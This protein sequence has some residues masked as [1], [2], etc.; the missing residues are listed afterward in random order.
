MK[1]NLS[2]KLVFFIFL[3][4]FIS[5]SQAPTVGLV[6]AGGGISEGYTLFSPEQNNEVYLIDNCGE[7]INS[8][9]FSENPGLT[10]YLLENGTLL[11]AGTDSLEIRSWDNTLIWSYELTS[12]NENQHH[13]I[14]PLP[15]GNIFVISTDKYS[16]SEMVALGR[17]PSITNNN[18]R[19]EKIIEIEPVGMNQANVVWEWK[20]IDHLIQ[21]AD[22]TKPNY[23]VI[24]DHPELLDI[25]YDNGHTGDWVHLN[26]IDY[27][28]QLDQIIISARHLGEIYIIDH[29]TTALEAAVHAGGVSNRGGDF[30]WRWGNNSVYQQG[31]INDQLLFEQ[32][33]A[34]WV[35][36][37]YPNE[38]KIS[39]FNNG[40]DGTNSFS[41]IHLIEPEI[42]GNSYGMASNQFL[43]MTYDWSWNGTL[44]GV[45]LFANKKCG[46]Q[47]LQNGNF[48][49]TQTQLGQAYEINSLGELVWS[50]KNPHGT[51]VYSQNDI[52]PNEANTIFRA[53]KYTPDF[54][55]FSG[56]TL[57]ASGPIENFNDLSEACTIDLGV[58]NDYQSI[59]Y[60]EN[61][62]S[63]GLIKFNNEV[64]DLSL[65]VFNSAGRIVLDKNHFSG[66]EIPL[67]VQKGLYFC[68][69][70]VNEI[71]CTR[72]IYVN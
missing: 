38:G 39:L 13:D 1:K 23:G 67:E 36:E 62:V 59:I 37:G 65:V 35:L 10:C 3:A 7:V 48:M 2:F 56:I 63:E 15:N 34:K 31:T 33:D 21:D 8:W 54:P 60:I 51:L 46:V 72:L 49:I 52:I 19:L 17:N 47:S 9:T 22:S 20:F 61:P 30:L 28:D 4:P 41:S 18:F 40:G 50:Y 64:E 70:T 26:G 68:I 6:Y 32:H 71:S 5:L 43:P 58:E 66:K 11:R 16:S 29:S 57:T 27:N 12:P 25:N 53:E 44:L 69:I 24:A 45:P 55:G 14:E 42:V